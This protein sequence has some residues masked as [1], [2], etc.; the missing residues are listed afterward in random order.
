MTWAR[1][2]RSYREINS[3]KFKVIHAIE[4]RLPLAPYYLRQVSVCTA[5]STTKYYWNPDKHGQ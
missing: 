2:I 5:D 1:G 3:A 4:R